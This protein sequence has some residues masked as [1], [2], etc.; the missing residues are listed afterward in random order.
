VTDFPR[1]QR[2]EAADPR[3]DDFRRFEYD[4]PNCGEILTEY[5]ER[6]PHCGQNLFEARSP[7]FRPRRT[8]T[9]RMIALVVL[10][11]F[12]AAVIGVGV[13]SLRE[14]VRGGEPGPSPTTAPSL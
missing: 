2:D 6:C 11:V 8:T 3:R 9:S 4:C 7:T 12:L 13:L 5:A 1:D 14:M 10:V